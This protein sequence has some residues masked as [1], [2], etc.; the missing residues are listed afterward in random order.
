MM[1]QKERAA[2]I[3]LARRH[4]GVVTRLVERWRDS[5]IFC[6]VIAVGAILAD[7]GAHGTAHA[8]LHR[9]GRCEMRVLRRPLNKLAVAGAAV[10]RHPMFGRAEISVDG[11][12]QAR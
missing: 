3:V 12:D 8:R 1:E 5:A 2:R 11:T 9:A 10:K 4:N 6:G 7:R